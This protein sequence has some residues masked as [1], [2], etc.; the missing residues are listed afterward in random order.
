[1]KSGSKHWNDFHNQNVQYLH[2]GSSISFYIY[3]MSHKGS[4]CVLQLLIEDFAINANG[5]AIL[6]KPFISPSYLIT[7]ICDQCFGVSLSLAHA[8]TEG[9]EGIL[10]HFR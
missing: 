8:C 9:V 1:M 6:V 5:D 2:H 7:H 10:P 4:L 3:C